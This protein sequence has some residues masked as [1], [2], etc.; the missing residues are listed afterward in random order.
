M[1]KA[2][3]SGARSTFYVQLKTKAT[4]L[5][6]HRCWQRPDQFDLLN[7]LLKTEGGLKAV[8]GEADSLLQNRRLNPQQAKVA[9]RGHTAQL[10]L[11]KQSFG[12]VFITLGHQAIEPRMLSVTGLDNDLSHFV[13]AAGPACD[14][15]YCLY[16]LFL[17]TK[18]WAEQANVGIQNCHQ[19]DVGKMVSLGQHL[20]A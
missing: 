10:S 1:Q 11:S 15:H 20:G 16:H 6:F 3:Q 14:L 8:P 13:R 18:I 7:Q 17:A 2:L 4:G 12:A 5:F 19:C 9:E